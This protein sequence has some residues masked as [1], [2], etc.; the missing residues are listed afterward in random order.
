M[1]NPN[2]NYFIISAVYENPVKSCIYIDYRV[3]GKGG[4][5]SSTNNKIQT[6][7]VYILK[8][9]KSD[10]TELYPITEK[11]AAFYG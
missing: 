3:P 10:K 8:T 4:I 1:V 2:I 5:I 11:K 6:N 9:D 7:T